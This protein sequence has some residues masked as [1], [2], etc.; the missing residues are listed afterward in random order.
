MSEPQLISPMLDGFHMGDVI[1]E[2]HGVRCY[3]AMPDSSD[4][5]YIVKI[6]SIPASQVQVQALLLAG[7]FSDKEAA[8]VYFRDLASDIM[9]EVKVLERLS[10]M[11][12]FLPYTDAQMVTMEDGVGSQVY[13]LGPYRTSLAKY[14][15][16]T[17]MTHLAAINLGL[18]MCASLAVCRQAGYLYTD[19]RPENIFVCNDHEFRIGDI[20][21]VKL[22]ALKYASIPE[23]CISAYTAPEIVDAYSDLNTTMD[24]YAAG[25]I[26]YQA[27]NGGE[28]PFQGRASDKPLAPPAYADYEL[29]EIILKACAPDPKDR[30]EDPIAMGQALVAYMQ[31][32][33][34]NDT[35]IV[36]APEE[37]PQ[38]A[39]D[40]VPEVTEEEV[41]LL[42]TEMIQQENVSL[43]EGEQATVIPD[44]SSLNDIPIPQT[45]DQICLDEFYELFD[46]KEAPIPPVENVDLSSILQESE[47]DPDAELLN[48]SFLD[49]LVSDDT[50][51][52]EDMANQI[53]Y[54][55]L[56]EDAF[57]ILAQADDLI[58]HET[59][60]GVVAPEPVE[61]PMPEPIVVVTEN[62]PQQNTEENI[63]PQIFLE[64]PD[65]MESPVPEEVDDLPQDNYDEGLYDDYRNHKNAKKWI[66]WIVV[67]LLLVGAAFGGYVFY[68]DYYIR[69]VTALTVQGN[70]DTLTVHVASDADDALL[71]VVCTDT[72]GNTQ[73]CQVLDGKATFTKLNP[74][75]LYTV[76]VQITGMHKLTGDLQGSYTTP[77]QTNIISFNAVTGNEPGSAILSFTVDGMDSETWSVTYS[78]PG[79]DEKKLI[80]SGHIVNVTGLESGKEYTFRLDAAQDLYIVGQKELVYTALDPVFAQ[81]LAVT[82]VTSDSLTVSWTV[83]E[84]AF[85]TGWTVRCYSESGYDQTVK[86][87]D[88]T[89]VFQGV[90]G[91]EAHTIEVVA[92]GMSSGNRCYMT[93]G[94]VTVSNIRWEAVNAVTM[95][96]KWDFAGNEPPCAWIITYQGDDADYQE[97]ARSETNS[98]TLSPLIPG[99]SYRISILLEDGTTIFSEPVTLQVPEAKDFYRNFL[100][101][102]HITAYMCR[103]PQGILDWEEEHLKAEDYTDTF[104]PGE[105][106]SFLLKATRN[107]E[108]ANE[109]IDIMYVFHT[110]DGK[111]VSMN[112]VQQIWRDMWYRRQCELDI[113]SLPEVP[114]DYQITVYWNGQILHTQA[115]KIAE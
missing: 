56:S 17:N 67:L 33:G 101:R 41:T 10:K 79:I 24:T 19:L 70:E 102:E 47:K 14:M 34:V 65:S 3:P 31:R 51:P 109:V 46:E 90:N 92:D 81:E 114:G 87:T 104:K 45:D 15:R 95:R 94:A 97:M 29:A 50:A 89:L 5:K 22:D 72:Y 111:L 78:A 69:S 113:P 43:A 112:I 40:P 9:K 26:L 61:I 1:N 62:E 106:A 57:D 85:V 8:A 86:T 84:G 2:H 68:K 7:A 76:K 83:P 53:V 88:T 48:L 28:M 13:L 59:P 30:W 36:A 55:D 74:N 107:Y 108:P 93:S 82:A 4:D 38:E 100:G 32:N 63:Q 12:G 27:Y 99:S 23:R 98:V 64:V 42:E 103:T 11:E 60:E 54:N 80:F 91:N 58:S 71:S 49:E 25:L 21:F 16:R 44:L 35:P 110:S 105:K 20:G 73:T 6:I 75:T 115:F 96:L 66:A 52:S 39:F 77:V 18:D 37:H